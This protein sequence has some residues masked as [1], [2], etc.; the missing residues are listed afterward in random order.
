MLLLRGKDRTRGFSPS[1]GTRSCSI[2]HECV[3]P[4]A[5]VQRIGTDVGRAE[6]RELVRP[7]RRFIGLDRHSKIW[8]VPS[9]I[10]ATNRDL[11]RA[12]A[13]GR[14]R[15]DLYYGVA[16]F[17][18]HLPTLRERGE[19]VLL[20]ADHIVRELGAKMERQSRA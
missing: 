17:R 20:L 5:D 13:E 1:P 9:L 16:V 4:H 15:E 11:E 2:A 6:A 10:A 3:N 8:L 18:I 12:V 14:F 7:K 19:D